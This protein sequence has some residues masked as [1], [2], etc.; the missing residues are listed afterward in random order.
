MNW[1]PLRMYENYLLQP[2]AI[3]HV[4]NELRGSA[5]TQI[6]NGQIEDWLSEHGGDSKYF[7]GE[8]PVAYGHEDWLLLVHGANLLED[9]FF[10]LTSDTGAHEYQKVKHGLQLTRYLV[11]HPTNHLQQLASVLTALLGHSPT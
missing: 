8:T 10:D 9:L 1:L 7:K 4:L 2:E 6:T 11:A 5:E 3:A